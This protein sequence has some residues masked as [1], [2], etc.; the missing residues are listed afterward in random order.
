MKVFLIFVVLLFSGCATIRE[1]PESC[2]P[3]EREACVI[4]RLKGALPGDS[5]WV[6]GC[7]LSTCDRE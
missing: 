1:L 5:V 3:A 6:P 2:R 7:G 4:A